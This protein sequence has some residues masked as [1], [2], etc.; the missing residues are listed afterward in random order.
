MKT[1]VTTRIFSLLLLLTLW[2]PACKNKPEEPAEGTGEAVSAAVEVEKPKVTV[3]PLEEGTFYK[4]VL[5]NGKLSAVQRADL[6]FRISERVDRVFVKNGDR[7]KQ[8]A[9][10]AVLDRFTYAKRLEQARNQVAK[11][12]LEMKDF[13]LSQGYAGKDSSQVPVNAWNVGLVRS[14]LKDSRHSLVLALH[15]YEN[16]EIL[17]PFDGIIANVSVK[18][19]NLASGDFCTLIDDS[20]FEAD[21]SVLESELPA[22]K[23]GQPVLVTPFAKDSETFQGT[24][25]SINPLVDVNGLVKVKAKVANKRGVLFEGM[26]VR[27]AVRYAVPNQMIIPKGALVLRGARTVV[28]TLEN[29]RS[30]WKDVKIVEEN[31]TQYAVTGLTPGATVI[32]SGNLNLGHD[33]EVEII[34]P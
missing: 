15:D 8:G 4:E 6:K 3:A 29:G 27:V 7:V 25:S 5:G 18:E 24:I 28:F 34:E 12:E 19:Q 14:G 16:T 26:N 21:F 1:Y 10:L 23:M 17:A 13:L 33:S 9:L 22:L 20:F 32:V 11:Q 30:M 2:L 31:S